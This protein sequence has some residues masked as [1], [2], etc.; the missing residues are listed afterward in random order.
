MGR[1]QA[2]IDR[3]LHTQGRLRLC[4]LPGLLPDGRTLCTRLL[5]GKVIVWEAASGKRLQ[6]WALNEIVGGVAYSPDSRHLAI[7]LDTG[8]AYIV[9]LGPAEKPAP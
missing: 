6:E 3:G 9:R 1:G 5:D 4:G 8:V 7:G 2:A